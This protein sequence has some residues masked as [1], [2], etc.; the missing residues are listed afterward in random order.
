MDLL[1]WEIND[2]TFNKTEID[3]YHLFKQT[4]LNKHFMKYVIFNIV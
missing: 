1:T 3:L 4:R 2:I